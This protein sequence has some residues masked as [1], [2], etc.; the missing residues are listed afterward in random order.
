MKL[1]ARH[2]VALPTFLRR[3]AAGFNDE[4]FRYWLPFMSRRTGI[5]VIRV[6]KSRSAREV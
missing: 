2:T 6:K 3:A 4:D 1:F 5:I